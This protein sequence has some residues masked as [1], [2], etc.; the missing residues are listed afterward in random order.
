MAAANAPW[1][2][3]AIDVNWAPCD[4]FPRMG[5]NFPGS[6]FSIA[7]GEEGGY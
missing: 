7:E 4:L 1:E 3:S 6:K 5:I 2:K